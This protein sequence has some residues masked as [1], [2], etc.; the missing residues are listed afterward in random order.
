MKKILLSLTFFAC[1]FSLTAFDWPQNEI[2]SDSFSVYYGQLRGGL[3][4]PSLV[5]SGSEEIDPTEP[6]VLPKHCE[7]YTTNSRDSDEGI[8]DFPQIRLIQKGKKDTF[9]SISAN[10]RNYLSK[11]DLFNEGDTFVFSEYAHQLSK[12]YHEITTMDNGEIFPYT[13]S[14]DKMDKS[15]ITITISK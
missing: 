12:F 7:I 9:G 1:L 5:F 10:A 2:A 15:H 14:F 8:N 3:L 11:A 13:I 4:S 6:H